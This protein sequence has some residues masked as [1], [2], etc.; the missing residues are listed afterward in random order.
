MNSSGTSGTDVYGRNLAALELR[1]PG[2]AGLV[3][4]TPPLDATVLQSRSGA[5]TLRC[6]NTFLHSRYDPVAEAEKL[7]AEAASTGADW[8]LCLGLGLGYSPRRLADNGNRV[9]IIETDISLLSTS[10]HVADLASLLAHP[11]VVLVLCPDGNGLS[12]FLAESAPRTIAVIEN[13]GIASL[14]PDAFARLRGQL[15]TWRSR[16]DINAATLRRFGRLWVRNLAKNLTGTVRLPGIESFRG[17]CTGLPGLLLA[18]GP[19]LDEC[20][21]TLPA[22]ARRTVVVCVDTALRTCLAAGVQPDFI[23]VVDPQY[24]NSRHLDRCNA[25]DSI[26]VTEAAVWPAVLRADHRATVLCS[27]IYPLGRHLEERLGLVRG[28]LGAGGSV[29]TSAWDFARFLGCSPVY[30]AGLDLGFPEGHT[31]ARSSLFEQRSLASGTRLHPTATDLFSAL[32]GGYPRLVASASG[33]Q[34]L[35]DARLSLY[36]SWFSRRSTMHPETKTLRLSDKGMLIDG[37]G[38]ADTAGLAHLPDIRHL[39]TGRIGQALEHARQT[40]AGLVPH[41]PENGRDR[42]AAELDRLVEE[43][44]RLAALA[45]RAV[46]VATDAIVRFGSADH[47]ATDRRAALTGTP[48]LSAGPGFPDTKET[49]EA[50]A[51]S[52]NSATGTVFNDRMECNASGVTITVDS[53]SSKS[54]GTGTGN[55]TDNGNGFKRSAHDEIAEALKELE[56]IDADVL[57]SEAREIAGFLF[58]SAREMVGGRS[59]TLG[60]SLE[61]TRHLYLT[62]AESARWHLDTIRRHASG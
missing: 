21:E 41:D 49:G 62:L 19:T 30:A 43:L 59:R 26:L 12:E 50:S 4:G 39:K 23:V 1:S 7:V 22:L 57:A 13:P 17:V 54:L 14:R 28:A 61:K 34:V 40:A 52:G 38:V 29:A 45:D 53:G 8:V 31:H 42:L 6:G 11:L 51:C 33:G 60:E 48:G 46:F 9:A 37:F 25:P 47:G 27:S 32:N 10:M 5:L 35:S 58:A 16:D 3:A 55:G 15:A 18:A 24:W 36:A 2:L 44:E 20:M 56:K